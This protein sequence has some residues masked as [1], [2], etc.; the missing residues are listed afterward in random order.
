MAEEW[1]YLLQISTRINVI[2]VICSGIFDSVT[3]EITFSF[4]IIYDDISIGTVIETDEDDEFE[5]YIQSQGVQK[6]WSIYGQIL[7]WVNWCME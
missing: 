2:T 7:Q 3:H 4:V 1:R 5:S 6:Y